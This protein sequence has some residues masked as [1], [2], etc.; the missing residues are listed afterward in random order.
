MATEDPKDLERVDQEIRINELKERARELSGGEMTFHENED[1]PPELAEQF[2]QQVV[3]FEE[4]PFTTVSR[5]LEEEGIVFPQADALDDAQLHDRLWEMIHALARLRHFIHGG[6]NHLSDRELY[7]RLYEQILPAEI[8]DVPLSKDG[9]WHIDFISNSDV[10]VM[11]WLRYYADEKERQDWLQ[12]FP[13]D[14]L[15]PHEE[16]AYDRDRFLPECDLPG[17]GGKGSDGVQ[18]GRP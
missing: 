3:A 4:G 13:E 1:L 6:T 9:A 15:P 11:D 12:Q 2:W 17:W 5:T 18:P 10:E 8:P 14:E 16:P 7:L